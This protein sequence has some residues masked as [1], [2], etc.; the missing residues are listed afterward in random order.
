MIKESFWK[1]KRVL[2]TGA[3]GFIGSHLCDNLLK[4]GAKVSI[5][6]R[7]I[8]HPPMPFFRFRN[9]EHIRDKFEHI[10]RGNLGSCETTTLIRKNNPEI[11]FH[12]GA[13]AYVP[14]SFSNPIEVMEANAMG[15]LYV[16]EAAREID[17]QQMVCTSSSEMYGPCKGPISEEH[18]LYPTSPYAASK[19]AADRLS[20]AYF[21]TYQLPVAIMRPFN[22]YGPRHTYD[23]IP[24]FIRLALENKPLTVHGDGKQTRDFAYVDDMIR[25]F[26]LM[27]QEKKARGEA[28]N[29]GT[30]EDVTILDIAKKILAQT[31][32]SSPIKFIEPRTAEV[33]KLLGDYSKAKR[34]LGLEPKI[35]I[36]E[37]LK[38]NISWAREHED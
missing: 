24:K 26:L 2:G 21:N 34:I 10:I 22:T 35:F 16:L 37:G 17:V 14:H 32:S 33:S 29:F 15:T 19:V 31:G 7:Y 30:G 6:T 36:D 11:L 8:S 4:F 9:L 28:I 18:P 23:V 13:D 5:F 1:G 25:G 20:Y 12:L 38:R 3:D 27:G